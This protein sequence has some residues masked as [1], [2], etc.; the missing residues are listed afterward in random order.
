V[1]FLMIDK[2]KDLF[3]KFPTEEMVEQMSAEQ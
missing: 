3:A 1:G 2:L